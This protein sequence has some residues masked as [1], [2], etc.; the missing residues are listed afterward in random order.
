VQ[1]RLNRLGPY[2][3]E[4]LKSLLEGR[5][6]NPHLAGI[7]AGAGEPRLP[8]PGFVMETLQANSS[9]F[10]RYPP[11]RGIE[12]LRCAV[13]EWLVRRYGLDRIDPAT[14][15]LAANGTREALFTVAHA[16]V[17]PEADHK[18]LILMPNPMYQIYLGAA[19]TSGAEPCFLPC[20][21]EHDFEPE[22][23]RVP[24]SVWERT[25]LVYVCS[26]SNPTG[27]VAAK[28]Y[29]VELLR[30]ADRYDFVVCADECYSEIYMDAAP[31]GLLDVARQLGRTGFERCLVFNSLSKRSAM[32]GLRS[33]FVAGDA[34]L[35]RQFA[36]LRSYTG[37]ATP[38]PL[39]MVAVEAWR[40][41]EH[42]RSS[43]QGFRQSLRAFY[44]AYGQDRIGK[45]PDGGFFVW[46]PVDDD[47]V[48]AVAAYEQQAV[49]I[50]PGRYLGAEDDEGNNP[51]R[52]FVRIA[53]LDGPEKATELARRLEQVN[54][55][56]TGR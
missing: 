4:R 3:F 22:L 25:A 29:Y 37:P 42:V 52:G 41:E 44:D 39:Q 33:G 54:V 43:R 49:T 23:S 1:P 51:G 46:L 36:K 53:L 26:P 5:T 27:W 15:I 2:P 32:P 21:A 47:E 34:R 56:D 9:G 35:I 12:T 48:F 13:A 24:D 30:L 10:S 18:P 11:T 8:L 16:M 38:S 50:L 45:I 31:T 7:D 55:E 17:D 40:D 20:L 6:P 19:I 28:A 14:Q